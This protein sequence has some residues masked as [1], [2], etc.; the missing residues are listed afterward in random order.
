M[1]QEK[2]SIEISPL[3]IE[4]VNEEPTK[5]WRHGLLL[6]SERRWNGGLVV[7]TTEQAAWIFREWAI[8]DPDYKPIAYPYQSTRDEINAF[9]KKERC[10]EVRVRDEAGKMVDSWRV[11]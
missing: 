1:N 3:I 8:K 7:F 2:R 11:E 10:S 9:A 6:I 5:Y 4:Q